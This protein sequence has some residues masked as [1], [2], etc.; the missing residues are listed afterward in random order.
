MSSMND[1]VSHRRN[2]QI[3]DA[4]DGNNLKQALQL[5]DKRLKKGDNTK[6]LKVCSITII[7]FSPS[8]YELTDR[9]KAWRAHV[10]IL[11]PDTKSHRRG[12]EETLTLC[13]SEPATTDLD[14]VE[15]L[16]DSLRQ[17]KGHAATIEA[18]WERA[19]KGKP[20]DLEIQLRWFEYAF[21]E[22]GWKSAQKVRGNT[23]QIGSSGKRDRLIMCLLFASAL[24]RHESPK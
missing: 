4:I 18:V 10:L 13:N 12:V 2:K 21:E 22:D 8:S 9:L 20:Q 23:L 16:C 19:A 3:Q 11:H 15:M 5:I 24:G 14:T 17:I 6:F 7:L 1:A